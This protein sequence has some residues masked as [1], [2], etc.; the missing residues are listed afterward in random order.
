MIGLLFA[1]KIF[2]FAIC[3]GAV[4]SVLVLVPLFIYGIPYILWVGNENTKGKQ[5]D[6]KKE[7]FWRTVKN[8]THL[9]GCWIRRKKPSF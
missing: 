1:F 6:K 5:L 9:Y 4:I 2:V 3:A 7:G 8:A